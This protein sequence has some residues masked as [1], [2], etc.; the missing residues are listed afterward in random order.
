MKILI[1]TCAEWLS[2]RGATLAR[3]RHELDGADVDVLSSRR[4]EHAAIWAR[5]IWER[6]EDVKGPVCIL[7][8]DVFTCPKFTEVI[9]VVA[10]VAKGRAISLHTSVP[11]AKEIPGPWLRAYWYTGPGVILPEGRATQLLEFWRQLPWQ[12]MAAPGRNEDVIAIHESWSRQEP[13]WNTIPALVR[14]DVQTRSSLGYDGHKLRSP[15]VDWESPAGAERPLTDPAYWLPTV[16]APPFVENP[17]CSTQYMQAVRKGLSLASCCHV[18]W[19]NS[20]LVQIGGVCICGNCLARGVHPVL[21]N[22]SPR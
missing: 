10:E 19:Q 5:R 20:T 22:A 17:W 16:D 1:A 12:F 8:D 7:N 2:E 4:P 13:F 6:A 15:S 11:Q 9:D 18:C 14:H 3:L 21:A